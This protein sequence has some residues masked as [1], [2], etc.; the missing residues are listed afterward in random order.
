MKIVVLLGV[1]YVVAGTIGS[2]IETVGIYNA[3]KPF[4]QN[5]NVSM[6]ETTMK[7]VDVTTSE[8]SENKLANHLNENVDELLSSDRFVNESKNSTIIPVTDFNISNANEKPKNI[9]LV[10]VE[11]NESENSWEKLKENHSFNVEGLIQG[12]KMQEKLNDSS[13]VNAHDKICDCNKLLKYNIR[14]LIEYARTIK[15]MNTATVSEDNFTLP[16]IADFDNLPRQSILIENIDNL[17]AIPTIFE[18]PGQLTNETRSHDIEKN[19]PPTHVPT[20][21]STADTENIPIKHKNNNRDYI[22]DFFDMMTKIRLDFFKNLFDSL[23]ESPVFNSNQKMNPRKSS[24]VFPIQQSPPTLIE[25]ISDTFM[26]F[27]RIPNDKGFLMIIVA[28]HNELSA[29]YQVI[30]SQS[31]TKVDLIIMLGLEHTHDKKTVFYVA[32]G[33]GSNYLSNLQTIYELPLKVKLILDHC[34]GICENK[35]LSNSTVLSTESFIAKK[36]VARSGDEDTNPDEEKS[37]KESSEN[38]SGN[39]EADV[40]NRDDES[41]EKQSSA[42]FSF[43]FQKDYTTISFS[44]VFSIITAVLSH[45]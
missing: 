37:E 21:A 17:V 16:T 11:G 22:W 9:I 41:H 42:G 24:L 44:I 14:E 26:K 27:R 10:I 6:P 33:P 43:H 25:L 36:R 31:S 40:V 28:P 3:S 38:E 2:T 5:D 12:C 7:I 35:E 34:Q 13:I 19:S 15:G 30:Q 4:V 18:L 29:I 1:L 23:N 39:E 20:K 8:I 32:N 45:T